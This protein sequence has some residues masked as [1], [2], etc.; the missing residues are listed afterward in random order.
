MLVLSL[1]LID[2]IEF[3]SSFSR[4]ALT[5]EGRNRMLSDYLK[6][7]QRGHSKNVM[8]WKNE[9][10]LEHLVESIQFISNFIAFENE[11]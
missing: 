3:M 4:Y 5:Y 1:L 6:F 8:N 9:H 10:K 11:R 7:Y 2:S